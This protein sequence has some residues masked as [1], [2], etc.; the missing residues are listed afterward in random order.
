MDVTEWGQSAKD[1]QDAIVIV[2]DGRITDVG[3][4]MAVSIPKGARVIDCTGKYPDSRSGGRVRRDEFAGPGQWNL[5]MGVTTV[6]ASNDS[7]RGPIDFS[8][9]PSPH[10]YLIDS[11]GTTDNAS[12][13]REA[14]GL[15]HPTERGIAPP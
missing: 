15:G 13:L 8:A 7:R 9:H 12:L 14:S 1:L 5:Y 11:I 6:V 3:S 2:R 4:R 10:L